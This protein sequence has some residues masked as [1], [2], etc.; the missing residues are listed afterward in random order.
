MPGVLKENASGR[1]KAGP[2]LLAATADQNAHHDLKFLISRWN[3][4]SH[5]V[6][7]AW[8]EFG[9]TLK[10]VISLTM[11]PV[12]KDRNGTNIV[13]DDKDERKLKYQTSAMAA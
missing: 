10:D 5:I 11:L 1:G 7:V 8:R 13:L 9:Q 6:I 2:E 12:Y 4:E 3:T